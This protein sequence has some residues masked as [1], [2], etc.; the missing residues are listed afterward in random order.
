MLQ[1]HSSL[2]TI[3]KKLIRKVL[4]MIRRIIE[5]DPGESSDKEKIDVEARNKDEKKGQYTMFWNEFGK[6]MKLGQ[7]DIFYITRTS[8][9]QHEKSP[10]LERL[11]EKNYKISK[12][13][14]KLGKDS[15]DKEVKDTIKD[16]MKWWKDVLVSENVDSVKTRNRLDNSPC[17]VETSKYRWSANMEWIIQLQTLSDA[18]KQAYMHGKMVLEINPRYPIIKELRGIVIS[19]PEDESLKQTTKFVYQTSLIE[20]GFVLSDPK[21]FA[22]S[23]YSSV[24]MSLKIN[25]DATIN[26][27]IE[28][29]EAEEVETPEKANEEDATINEGTDT[30]PSI[31]IVSVFKSGTVCS[32]SFFAG[33]SSMVLLVL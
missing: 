28:A 13:G 10:F 5:E 1:Q 9:V 18:N 8:K 32:S 25:S 19:N 24:K 15:K 2:K 4:D 17:V 31:T 16:L 22:N 29:D 23:I 12:E 27:E 21:E 30:E 14:L 3:K 33:L 11:T 6:S 26:E 20:S 7:K